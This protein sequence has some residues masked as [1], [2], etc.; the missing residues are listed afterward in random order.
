[1]IRFASAI[2]CG[3]FLAALSMPAAAQEVRVVHDITPNHPR[4]PYID[5]VASAAAATEGATAVVI[6]PN[7]VVYPGFA[8]VEAV[9]QGNADVA[10]VNASN[11]ERIDPRLGFVNLPFTLSDK[12]ME[13][14]ATRNGV[15]ALLDEIARESG[16]RVLGLMRGADQLFLFHAVT[17]QSPA[18]LKGLKIRVA[19]AG[20]Y[21]N[22]MRNFGAE[23]VVMPFPELQRAFK[24][25][26]VDGVFTSPGGWISQFGMDAPNALHA[27]G[28][29]MITY[30][31]ITKSERFD[32]LSEVD[33]TALANA[34]AAEVTDKWMNMLADDDAILEEMEGKGARFVRAEANGSW[35]EPVNSIPE[36]FAR[37]HPEVWRAM[38]KLLAASDR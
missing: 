20:T 23:P 13:D 3:A 28:L 26:Q 25:A 24:E 8:S 31:V 22:I 37:E 6:N 30:A 14:E 7:G 36:S 27:P 34:V 29:M 4:I 32:A 11:L 5:A 9:Q 16:W 38:E 21:E 19:G 12:L 17:P 15:V 33:R 18:D 35:R 10:L 1:M 2:V